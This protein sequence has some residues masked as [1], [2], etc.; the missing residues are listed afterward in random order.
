M[1]YGMGQVRTGSDECDLT[2]TV[3][4]IGV[5][6]DATRGLQAGDVLEVDLVAGA[7]ASTAVCRTA[8]GATVGALAA[9][10]GLVSLLGCLDQGCGSRP[11]SRMS[12]RRAAPLRSRGPRR[13]RRR[14]HIF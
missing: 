5:R 13:E 8:D 4:L 10:R 2:F 3:D 14:R 1:P 11:S 6:R 9:F 7:G 12:A